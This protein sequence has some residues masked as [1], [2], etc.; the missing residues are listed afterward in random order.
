MLGI[1]K[2]L[3]ERYQ[4]K[5]AESKVGYGPRKPAAKRKHRVCTESKKRLSKVRGRNWP[6]LQKNTRNNK[7]FSEFYRLF[8]SRDGRQTQNFV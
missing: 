8:Q 7:M 6:L 4:D 1:S 2:C 3:R 5:W